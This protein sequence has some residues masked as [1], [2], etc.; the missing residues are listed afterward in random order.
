[1]WSGGPSRRQAAH[2]C[3]FRFNTEP[4]W[5]ASRLKDGVWEWPPTRTSP[6]SRRAH[7]IEDPGGGSCCGRWRVPG[8]SPTRV[9]TMK[10][11]T[12]PCMFP[13]DRRWQLQSGRSE[14]SAGTMPGDPNPGV[15][16]FR[17][18]MA[19]VHGE[20]HPAADLVPDERLSLPEGRDTDGA[21]LFAQPSPWPVVE[22]CALIRVEG[23]CQRA[24]SGR[25][26]IGGTC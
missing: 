22:F 19:P 25:W 26:P 18:L 23:L 3:P 1:M 24:R 16:T 13:R 12:D 15:L 9:C 5:V 21:E 11:A 7:C 4:P 17:E 2:G 10:V 8:G 14:A 20:V 6:W